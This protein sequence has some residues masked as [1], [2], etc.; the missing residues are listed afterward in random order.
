MAYD[1]VSNTAFWLTQ[2]VLNVNFE[3]NAA[4]YAPLEE[5]CLQLPLNIEVPETL[6]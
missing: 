3:N 6:K 5:R 4:V 1:Y 2:V